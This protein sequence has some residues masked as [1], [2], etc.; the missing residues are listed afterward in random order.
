MGLDIK[1]LV[2]IEVELIEIAFSVSDNLGETAI[3]SAMKNYYDFLCRSKGNKIIAS[4][5]I[6]YRDFIV[7]LVKTIPEK[8]LHKAM[9]IILLGF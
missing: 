8:L 6:D 2:E 7:S 9:P 4:M 3:K 5:D 1:K